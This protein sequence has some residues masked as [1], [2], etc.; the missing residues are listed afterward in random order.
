MDTTTLSF[1]QWCDEYDKI[2]REFLGDATL[3]YTR[4]AGRDSYR[5]HYDAGETPADA[6]TEE[7]TYWDS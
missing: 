5:E 2:A 1:D 4:E 6:F 3:S 7:R